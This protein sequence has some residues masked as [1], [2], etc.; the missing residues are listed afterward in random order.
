MCLPLWFLI[1]RGRNFPRQGGLEENKRGHINF[2]FK[3]RICML[4]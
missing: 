3:R 1:E 4:I 2:F